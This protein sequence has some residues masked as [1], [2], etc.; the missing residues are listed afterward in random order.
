M[1]ATPDQ[2]ECIRFREM[3]NESNACFHVIYVDGQITLAARVNATEWEINTNACFLYTCDNQSGGIK[4]PKK[5]CE[6]PCY[7]GT[8]NEVS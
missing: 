5:T 1:I 2:A 3:M 7:I 6:K 4:T 8:C